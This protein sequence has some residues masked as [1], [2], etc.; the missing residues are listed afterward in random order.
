MPKIC[1]RYVRLRKDNDMSRNRE[2][3]IRYVANLPSAICQASS[4][5]VEGRGIKRYSHFV[6]LIKLFGELVVK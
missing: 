3:D 5:R 1:D 6:D 2:R 4:G